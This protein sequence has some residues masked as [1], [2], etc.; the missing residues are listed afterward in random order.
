MRTLLTTILLSLMLPLLAATPARAAGYRVEEIP[1]VQLTDRNRYVSNPDRILSEAAVARIDSLCGSL[2]RQGIAQVAVVAVDEI[3]GDDLFTFA[4]DLFRRWGVGRAGDDNGV[5]ILLVRDRREIRFV[6]GYGVEG[7]LTDALCK[8]IQTQ[9]MLPRF[10]TGDYSGGMVAG[11]EAVAGALTGSGIAFGEEEPDDGPLPV[12]YIF[13]A[14]ILFFLAT[15]LLALHRR[16]QE[17]RCPRCHKHTLVR[18]E[19][20]V[21]GLTPPSTASSSIP[22]SARTAA[23]WCGAR[24]ANG[25][26]TASE[27]AAE[28]PS[29]A[30]SADWAASAAEGA[31][32]AEASAEA[33]SEAAA[34]AR[35]GSPE[36]AQRSGKGARKERTKKG[37]RERTMRR[38]GRRARAAKRSPAE[39][40]RGEPQPGT[41]PAEHRRS[42]P[43]EHR[44]S[45]PA[46]TFPPPPGKAPRRARTRQ[47]AESGPRQQKRQRKRQQ[48]PTETTE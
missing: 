1:N 24:S 13:G 48:Q 42:A 11:V 3:A 7:V 17:K 20:R 38:P 14:V 12:L 41:A 8:R 9:L 35:A 15:S 47:A 10:R 34:P 32:W 39:Q 37:Q 21:L 18:E 22:S 40:R 36:D 46:G 16:R 2:R 29:S 33:A 44:R 19:R 5:G 23:M 6:T 30:A 25:A 45:P 27:G 28:G 4:I 43:A 31:P 26:T